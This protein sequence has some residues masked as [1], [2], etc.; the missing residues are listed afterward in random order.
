VSIN[1][2]NAQNLLLKDREVLNG[3]QELNVGFSLF[4]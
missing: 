3:L 1:A 2:S 4:T